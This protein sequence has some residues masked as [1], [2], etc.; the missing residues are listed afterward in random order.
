[1]PALAQALGTDVDSLLNGELAKHE[2]TPEEAEA[3]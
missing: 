1:L 3:S 2:I